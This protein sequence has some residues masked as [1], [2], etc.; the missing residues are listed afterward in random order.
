MNADTY[1]LSLREA[2]LKNDWTRFDG[3]VAQRL[4]QVNSSL[5]ELL[6]EEP[7]ANDGKTE[8]LDS[9]VDA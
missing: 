7:N 2:V 9:E 8:R 3:I 4:E 5:S 6:G 1:S